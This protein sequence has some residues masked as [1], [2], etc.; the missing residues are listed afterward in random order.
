M[1]AV[2]LQSEAKAS[3]RFSQACRWSSPRTVDRHSPVPSCLRPPQQQ[4]P[5]ALALRQEQRKAAAHSAAHPGE[6]AAPSPA[7]VQLQGL[8]PSL[9]HTVFL[10]CWLLL[11]SCSSL[12]SAWMLRWPWS[13]LLPLPACQGALGSGERRQTPSLPWQSRGAGKILPRCLA[14]P[15]Q[16]ARLPCMLSATTVRG[17]VLAPARPPSSPAAPLPAR[18]N[19]S[20]RPAV[21]WEESDGSSSS[22]RVHSIQQKTTR[23]ILV[24]LRLV[25]RRC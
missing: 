16:R 19:T 12:Q 25:S 23:L 21:T 14:L 15:R 10:G 5:A 3:P 20:P 4:P 1:R 6:P 24:V 8:R 17:K 7:W 18:R 22:S 9:Y 11:F 13:S 2:S